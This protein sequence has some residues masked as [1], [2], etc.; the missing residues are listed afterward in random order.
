MGTPKH[1]CREHVV[2]RRG[3][4]GGRK[5]LQCHVCRSPVRVPR[6]KVLMRVSA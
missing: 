6:G 1:N 2:E 5:G 3:P 4:N